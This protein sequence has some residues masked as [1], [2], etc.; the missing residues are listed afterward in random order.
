MFG[1]KGGDTLKNGFEENRKICQKQQT[2]LRRM[3]SNAEQFQEACQLFFKQHAMLHSARISQNEYFSLEDEVFENLGEKT[4]RRIPHNSDH[5]IIWNI[6]HIARIEDVTMNL[7][8][9]GSPQILSKENWLPMLN[10]SIHDTGNAMDGQA[11]AD[12]SDS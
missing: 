6:W 4:A 1:F 10:V 8:V 3:L 9:A 5:S 2:E 7:L 12:T 11:V